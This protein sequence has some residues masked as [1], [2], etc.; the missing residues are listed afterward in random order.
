M[1][2]LGMRAISMRCLTTLASLLLASVC[3]AVPLTPRELTNAC[4]GADGLAHCGRLVEEIQIK[5]YPNLAA[6]DG[7]AL[8]VTLFPTGRTSFMD[9]SDGSGGRSYSLWDYMDAA[10]IVVIYATKGD[11]ATFLLLQ[12]TNGRV[13]E[14]PAEPRKD[15]RWREWVRV[16]IH[17]R[18]YR[19]GKHRPNVHYRAGVIAGTVSRVIVAGHK[20]AGPR[21]RFQYSGTNHR[22]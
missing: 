22:G 12:R 1:R 16:G 4:S 11:D 14:V 6:R 3:L 8:N 20:R 9:T 18:R 5:R 21:S 10:N 13:F 19:R 7:D 2:A 17:R 15:G